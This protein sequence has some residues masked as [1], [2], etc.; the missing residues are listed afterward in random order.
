MK[1]AQC[2][3]AVSAKHRGSVAGTIG[4]GSKAN[5]AEIAAAL[6]DPEHLSGLIERLPPSVHGRLVRKT[7]C[8]L[9][10]AAGAYCYAP[11]GDAADLELE[12]HGLAFGFRG[13]WRTE[14]SLPEDLRRPVLEALAREH[15]EG[16]KSARAQRWVGAPLQ[17]AHDAAAVWAALHREPARVKTDGDLYQRAWPKLEAALPPL[18]V[19]GGQDALSSR[20]LGAALL[21]L[22]QEGCLRV[23][24]D[25]VSGWETKRQLV[26]AGNLS[27]TL[28]S[29]P[30]ALRGSLLEHVA[31]ETTDLAGLALLRAAA[32]RSAVSLASFGDALER[33]LEPAGD[34][35]DPGLTRVQRGLLGVQVA[36]L[37]G[38]A[39]IGFGGDGKPVAV[40]SANV[41]FHAS[42]GSG[43]AGAESQASP[44]AGA[45][46]GEADGAPGPRAVCQGNFEIVLLA[47]PSPAQ[48]LTLELACEPVAGQPHVYRITRRSV[49]VGERAGV[50]PGG[51][52]GAL[53]RLTGEMP[54]NVARS[55]SEWAAAAG[56][57]LRVRT[58]MMLDAGDA[59][60]AGALASGPLAGLVVER[61]GER[62]LA[63]TAGRLDELGRALASAGRELEPGVEKNSG[64][65]EQREHRE[66]AVEHAW[67]P[68]V[69]AAAP[70]ARLV[71]TLR[72]DRAAPEVG[73]EASSVDVLEGLELD[74]P[75]DVIIEAIENEEEVV[76]V[77]AGARGVRQR[78]IRPIDV[79]G[80]QVVAVSGAR[81]DESK[82]WIQSII[83]AAALPG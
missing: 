83:A 28:E 13:P 53:G 5:A 43:A 82:F 57:P 23:R 66:S 73:I 19:F 63:F 32:G 47:H 50:G 69:P 71:S 24:V 38:L 44:G 12:R 3:G 7:L 17:L 8:V 70:K 52:L 48:R 18:D 65:W 79:D 16:M 36:W 74:G 4:L 20:R 37:L 76:I 68:H 15:L 49:C 9:A 35:V 33:F 6:L 78:C 42:R 2:L 34:R 51:V 30:L 55:V 46:S 56:P 27:R 64:S 21:A 22:R 39:E 75:L 29:D 41:E 60:T 67:T 61:V 45:A 58:A 40:R 26:P 59:Q 1:L 62:M 54:Q 81:G 11:A 10:E 77:Y 25:D 72:A 14:Y 31:S 80:S